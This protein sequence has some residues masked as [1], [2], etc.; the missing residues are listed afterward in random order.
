MKKNRPSR[1]IPYKFSYVHHFSHLHAS[2]I[3]QS[4]IYRTKALFF[5]GTARFPL[6]SR[7]CSKADFVY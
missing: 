5:T 7:L 1:W 3:Q 2:C 4:A 6:A